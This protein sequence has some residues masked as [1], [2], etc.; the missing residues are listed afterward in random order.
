MSR[1]AVLVELT[2]S[3]MHQLNQPLAAILGNAQAMEGILES[4]QPSL[5]E[6]RSTVNPHG[7]ALSVRRNEDRGSTF[8]ISLPTRGNG[9]LSVG[10]V[11]QS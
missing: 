3:P 10:G 9:E 6:L 1:T 4:D 8:Q 2:A 11:E 5:E 7:G